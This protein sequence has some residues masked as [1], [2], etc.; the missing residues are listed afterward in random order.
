LLFGD[1]APEVALIFGYL[2]AAIFFRI[3]YA[4]ISRYFY[5]QKD[6][7]TPLIVSIFAIILNVYLAFNL[8][9]PEVLGGYGISGLALAQSLV[10]MSEVAVLFCVMIAR[11]HK[12]IDRAFW[13]GCVR[14]LSVTGFSI[15]AA[16]AMISILPLQ[17]A[18]TGIVTLGAKFGSIAGMT[19]LTHLLISSLFGLEEVRPF[20]NRVR[21][22]ILRPV[23]IQ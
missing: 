10:A 21:Q 14:I 7:W 6:T 1:V 5:A 23:K 8:A 15:L 13:G 20:W 3:L 19:L 12:L 2:T 16:F 4:L 9:K 22:F 18:D 17:R 11:D